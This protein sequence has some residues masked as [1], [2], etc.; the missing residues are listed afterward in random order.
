MVLIK[1]LL[2]LHQYLLSLLPAEPKT[3]RSHGSAESDGLGNKNLG[4]ILGWP[5]TVWVTE[6][7]LFNLSEPW[8]RC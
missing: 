5:L 1:Y 6:S 3:P 7:N 8:D 2:F 4:L